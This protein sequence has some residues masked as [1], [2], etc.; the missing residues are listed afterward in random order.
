MRGKQRGKTREGGI[1]IIVYLA[2]EE[3]E[4]ERERDGDGGGAVCEV[5]RKEA[6]E[7][8]KRYEWL[9]FCGSFY[10]SCGEGGEGE[11]TFLPK[12]LMK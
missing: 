1:I 6:I 10:L 7:V 9:L 11:E 12:F 2:R 8:N 5:K 3:R 4:R